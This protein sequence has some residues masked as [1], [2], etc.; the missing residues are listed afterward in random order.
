MASNSFKYELSFVVREILYRD[1]ES[2]L[3]LILEIFGCLS[4]HCSHSL[5]KGLHLLMVACLHISHLR[6]YHINSLICALFTLSYLSGTLLVLGLLTVNFIVNLS[7]SNFNSVSITNVHKLNQTYDTLVIVPGGSCC[8]SVTFV[9]DY[10]NGRALFLCVLKMLGFAL[11]ADPIIATK[12]TKYLFDK[13]GLP[14]QQHVIVAYHL[15]RAACYKTFY[16]QITQV[17]FE[18]KWCSSFLKLSCTASNRANF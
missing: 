13:T 7:H 8:F 15:L 6:F 9:A 17:F 12:D 5:N 11:V 18:F 1:F 16:L 4:H 2:Q 14:V 10:R 3:K